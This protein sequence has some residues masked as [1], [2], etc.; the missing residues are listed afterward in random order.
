MTSDTNRQIVLAARSQGR[1]AFREDVVDGLENAP[2]AFQRLFDGRNFG[3][4]L[5]RVSEE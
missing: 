3:K 2:A 4:L 1:L 5:V